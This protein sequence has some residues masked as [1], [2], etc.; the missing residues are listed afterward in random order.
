M[1][2][3]FGAG[4]LDVFFE[5]AKTLRDVGRNPAAIVILWLCRRPDVARRE[6]AVAVCRDGHVRGATVGAQTARHPL[7]AR[8]LGDLTEVFSMA[9]ESSIAAE[10]LRQLD[11]RSLTP[12]AC[13]C[14]KCA[15]CAVDR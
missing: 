10:A 3:V 2:Q 5:A 9:H 6:V 13:L 11:S 7:R 8:L 1:P 4:D 14:V 12:T 15:R